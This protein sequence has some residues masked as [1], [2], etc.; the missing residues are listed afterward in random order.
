MFNLQLRIERPNEVTGHIKG[1]STDE[2]DKE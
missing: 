2:H 1:Y